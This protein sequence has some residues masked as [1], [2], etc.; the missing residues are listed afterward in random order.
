MDKTDVGNVVMNK[1]ERDKRINELLD[2]EDFDYKDYEE[3]DSLI[4]AMEADYYDLRRKYQRALMNI[5]E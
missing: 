2:K 1:E 5:K 4:K 3:I